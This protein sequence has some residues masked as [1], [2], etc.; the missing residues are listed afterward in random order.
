MIIS[1]TFYAQKSLKVLDLAN[2]RI[3]TLRNLSELNKLEELW[4]NDNQLNSYPDIE[5]QLKNLSNLSCVYFERNP[6]A[7]DTQ[8]R[9]KVKLALPQ[10]KQLDASYFAR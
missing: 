2:N 9:L 6:L 8:Y 4:I 1:L 5:K 7:Q 10:L 3:S